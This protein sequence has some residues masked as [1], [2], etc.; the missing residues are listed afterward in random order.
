MARKSIGPS[1]LKSST[2]Q[3]RN[4][5]SLQFTW[6]AQKGIDK[7][8]IFLDNGEF[9]EQLDRLTRLRDNPRF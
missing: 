8:A 9:R 2:G 7:I 6:T 5:K 3:D 4:R 1:K